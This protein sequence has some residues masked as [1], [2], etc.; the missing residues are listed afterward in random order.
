MQLQSKKPRKWTQLRNC[1]VA[2]SQMLS[3]PGSGR[4][5]K[6]RDTALIYLQRAE[7]RKWTPFA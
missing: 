5:S 7:P 1:A 3:S 2:R 6:M 4:K